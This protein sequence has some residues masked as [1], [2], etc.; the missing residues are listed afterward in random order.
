VG[1]EEKQALIGKIAG[2]MKGIPEYIIK[3]AD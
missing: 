1:A 2:H 3:L